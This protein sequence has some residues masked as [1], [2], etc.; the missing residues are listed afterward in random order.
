MNSD[1]NKE[2]LDEYIYDYIDDLTENS[3]KYKELSGN[4]KDRLTEL[5][6]TIE[7]EDCNEILCDIDEINTFLIKLNS[8]SLNELT[9]IK[10]N[11][12]ILIKKH[13]KHKEKIMSLKTKNNMLEEDLSNI[14]E[15][16]ENALLKLDE[17]ND[18][19]YKLYQEK[20]NLE[21]QM[22]IKEDEENQKHKLNNEILNDEIKNLNDKIKYLN[23][24]ISNYEEKIKNYSKKNKELFEEI[25]Q[26]KKELVCKD[27]I[28]RTSMEKY[29]NLNEEKESYRS[30][31]RGLNQTIEDLKG[32]CLDYQTIIK[33]NED[34]IRQLREQMNKQEHKIDDR[35][36]SLNSLI[37]E[38]E[39]NEKD[40]II[41]DNENKNEKLEDK[42]KNEKLEDKNKTKENNAVKPTQ[43]I[44]LNELIFEESESGEKEREEAIEKKNQIKLAFTRVKH[45]RRF[46]KLKSLNYNNK[47]V[48]FA[49][50]ANRNKSKKNLYFRG[51]TSNQ[52][53]NNPIK[54]R[55]KTIKSE[56]IDFENSN[57]LQ[58]LR[59]LSGSPIRNDNKNNDAFL[60]EL[61]FN[62][63]EY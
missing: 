51:I 31:N 43:E 24:Q 34:Q 8:L 25:S 16:K 44:N 18:E 53:L 50:N 42:N 32:N 49:E 10:N 27:E 13:L 55:L 12:L 45:I 33:Y 28:I 15:Q 36:I 30:I 11:G 41:I 46:T 6:D 63:I 47:K 58:K 52:E 37:E 21:L 39:E 14:T 5:F 9:M 29:K 7:D 3:E 22:S 59:N 60:Y 17:L 1:K 23:K 56:K 54:P 62:F 48:S 19:Y 57:L 35:K 4:L 26:M 38:E 61:L 40:K 2:Y 20:N